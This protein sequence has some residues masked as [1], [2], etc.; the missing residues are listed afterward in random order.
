MSDQ[1]LTPEEREALVQEA[2]NRS[3]SSPLPATREM[4][5]RFAAALRSDGRRVEEL[6][7]RV[8]ARVQECV[9]LRRSVDSLRPALQ[10][11]AAWREKAQAVIEEADKIE[12]VQGGPALFDLRVAIGALRAYERSTNEVTP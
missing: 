1:P 6:E 2:A 5:A 12:S 11:C 10:R 9:E 4:M 7:K 8:F 3:V